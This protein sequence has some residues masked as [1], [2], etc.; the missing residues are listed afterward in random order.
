MNR[1]CVVGNP[2]A[3]SKSPHIHEQF[4]K[5]CERRIQYS[6]ILIEKD[7]FVETL[8][9]MFSNGLKGANVTLPFK[10]EAF[11][12]CHSISDR[13]EAAGAVNTII[14]KGEHGLLGD[15][16][17]GVG[18]VR[19][20]VQNHRMTLNNLKILVVGAGGATRGILKPILEENPASLIV[21][22]RTHSKACDL[23]SV[24]KKYGNVDSC[25]FQNLEQHNFDLILNA[26]SG[27]LNGDVPPIPTNAINNDC[28]FYDL[29]YAN[30][31][32]AFLLWGREL[33]L[34]RLFDGLGML[35]EQAA[36]SFY[37]WEGVRPDTK[38]TIKM[39]RPD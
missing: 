33:G 10:E 24:F 21:A 22:N 32:T 16:T 1:Y 38:S 29:M 3:H 17:D 34:T 18:L 5:T 12:L 9:D 8:L 28:V 13:A 27:S 2:I 25:T 23:A 31:A 20:L 6:K 36:E 39:L 4:A 30:E 14:N 35:V 7:K 26:S 19:D 37:L 11:K 15:N